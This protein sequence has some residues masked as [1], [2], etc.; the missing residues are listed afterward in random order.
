[1]PPPFPERYFEIQ[2][3]FAQKVAS[4]LCIP[5][6]EAL[7]QYTSFYRRMGIQDKDFNRN[8]PVWRDF[9][10]RVSQGECVP[11]I[12]YLI[13][14]NGLETKTEE[15]GEFGCFRYDYRQDSK[16]IVI[17]FA[18]RVGGKNVSPLSSE[19]KAERMSE[20]KRMF[21]HI[22]Y[23]LPEAKLVS[24]GSWLYDLQSYKRLFPAEYI[25]SRKLC[26]GEFIQ[27]CS[28]WGQFLDYFGNLK[29]N[30]C[31][32]FLHRMARAST[33]EELIHS[34]PHPTYR[35]CTEIEYFYRFYEFDFRGVPNHQSCA[36]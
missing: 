36:K 33:K 12:A 10:E 29:E 11:K 34:F 31:S 3:T 27:Y 35:V 25:N 28:T 18:N 14:L 16:S 32:E 7:L 30:L 17:H 1:M 5:I 8:S 21:S 23:H 9:V 2:Y 19:R 26:H 22:S 24:G 13:Y 4:V 6:D 20:L 15:I